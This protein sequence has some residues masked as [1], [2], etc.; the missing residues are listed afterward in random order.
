MASLRCL[1]PASLLLVLALLAP[2][3]AFAATNDV[4]VSRLNELEPAV[5]QGRLDFVVRELAMSLSG[6]PVH[7]VASLGLYEFEVATSHRLAFQHT[8]TDGPG[9]SAWQD[10]TEGGEPGTIGY[11]PTLTFRKGLPWSFEVGGEA[12]WLAGTRQLMV[13]G[14]GRWA[15][16]GGWDKVP[17]VAIQLGYDGY[18]GNDQLELG[19]FELDASVGYT[20]KASSKRER[21]GT[22]F[23]PFVGYGYL[24]THA[25]PMADV[26]EVSAVTAWADGAAT[27]V[28]PRDFRFHR[29]FGGLEILSGQVAFRFGGDVTAPRT[30]PLLGAFNMSL[31]ARF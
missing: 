22:R 29:F 3:A 21:P 30:G 2:V 9:T 26:D 7:A 14:Y 19:V 13:G 4:T 15:F 17:D 28:D 12:G 16:V 5:R 10:L 8:E 24:M 31:G 1:R 25:R 6:P 11:M 18:V 20:F 27:G 23:S